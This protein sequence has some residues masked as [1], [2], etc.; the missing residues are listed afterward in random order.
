MKL[1]R[2][3]GRSVDGSRLKEYVEDVEANDAVKAIEITMLC[4]SVT[5]ETITSVRM[6]SDEVVR[7]TG[8]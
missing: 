3:K 1:F 7:D 8:P 6:L 4:F 2:V 5:A